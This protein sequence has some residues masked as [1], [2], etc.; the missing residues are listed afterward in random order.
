MAK[1]VAYEAKIYLSRCAASEAI[2]RC[3]MRNEGIRASVPPLTVAPTPKCKA[4]NHRSIWLEWRRVDRDAKGD[5]SD[6]IT[7]VLSMKGGYRP[8]LVGDAVVVAYFKEADPFSEHGASG[9][10]DATLSS[11]ASGSTVLT[12]STAGAR[13]PREFPAR[14]LADNGDGTF[15]LL[16][17]DGKTEPSARRSRI[18][19][20]AEAPWQ[21]VYVGAEATC[22][23]EAL[24]PESLLVKEPGV[25]LTVEFKLETRGGEFGW[26]R[27][28]EA[29]VPSQELSRP[30][31]VLVVSTTHAA[32][33]NE[34]AAD[35]RAR[36]KIKKAIE[37]DQSIIRDGHSFLSTGTGRHYV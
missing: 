17:D 31:A 15:G 33:P 4:R 36:F 27:E 19:H 16:Y 23:V 30:S 11:L 34:E 8:L 5:R 32:D 37:T 7:H 14:I 13:R 21:T 28:N 3:W 35:S 25:I 9:D 6:D 26:D 29:C 20:A 22:A 10:D 18:R 12:R 24:I 1:R 2:E